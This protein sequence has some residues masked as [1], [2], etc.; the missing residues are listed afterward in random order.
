MVSEKQ[1]FIHAVKSLHLYSKSPELSALVQYIAQPHIQL[2]DS[3]TL[4]QFIIGH[5]LKIYPSIMSDK[6][7]SAFRDFCLEIE[8]APSPSPRAKT[9]K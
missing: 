6:H 7:N 8:E 4:S 1:K 9:K 3:V 2:P 5:L